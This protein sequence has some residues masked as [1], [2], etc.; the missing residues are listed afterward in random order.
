VTCNSS[1]VLRYT[2]CFHFLLLLSVI[3]RKKFKAGSSKLQLQSHPA[4]PPLPDFHDTP[5]MPRAARVTTNTT[6]AATAAAPYK[7]AVSKR[8]G[9]K[10]EPGSAEDPLLFLTVVELAGE[11]NGEVPIYDTCDE[12]RRKIHAFF[13]DPKFSGVT[14]KR[15]R[16]ECGNIAPGSYQLFMKKR[17]PTAGAEM[18]LYPNAWVFRLRLSVR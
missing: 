1:N 17:G 2:S 7:K 3:A 10:P 18:V 12:I 16:E 13:R 4:E 15:F 8:G 5:T 6:P 11:D 9:K 14:Q